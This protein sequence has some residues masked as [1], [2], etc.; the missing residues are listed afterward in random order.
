MLPFPEVPKKEPCP[1]PPCI[2]TSPWILCLL[3][4]LRRP[5]GRIVGPGTLWS[6]V[7]IFLLVLRVVN[8][9]LRS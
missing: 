3:L 5:R 4:L 9:L 2:E 8:S 7:L 1:L 6:T